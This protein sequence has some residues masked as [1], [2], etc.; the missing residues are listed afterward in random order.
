MTKKRPRRCTAVRGYNDRVLL[1]AEDGREAW[2]G[3]EIRT[4]TGSV[5]RRG[6][7]RCLTASGLRRFLRF[8]LP[9]KIKSRCEVP[10]DK[11]IFDTVT[12]A[13]L[14]LAQRKRCHATVPIPLWMLRR[15]V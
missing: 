7:L 3:P 14:I 5:N 2:F 15:L 13:R 10:D 8:K 6:E 9:R 1:V 11:G 12:D 4:L